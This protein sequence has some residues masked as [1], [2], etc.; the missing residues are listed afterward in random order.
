[1]IEE[2]LRKRLRPIVNRR[3]RLHL[4]YLLSACWII[5]ALV[6]IG[7]I[8]VN[9]YLGLKSPIA[10]WALCISAVLATLYALYR[11]RRIRPDYQA[12][13]RHIERQNPDMQALLLAAIEQEPEQPDDQFGYLQDR[14]IGEAVRHATKH[15]WL[16]S[17]SKRRLLSAELGGAIALALIITTLLQ[18]L[19]P[20]PFLRLTGR[21]AQQSRGYD[22]TVTPGDTSVE[23]G[24]PVVI[25]ARFGRRVPPKATLLFGESG[26]QMKQISLT[27]NLDDPVFGGIIQEVN[28]NL[29]YYIEYADKRSRDYKISIYERPVLTRADAKIIFPSYTKLPEKVIKDTRQ[30]SVAEGSQ[31]ILTFVLNKAVAK[32]QLVPK[33]G[34]GPELTVDGEHPNVYT[35]SITAAQN[36]RYE[37]HLADAQGLTNEVPERFVIDVHKNLP[38]ELKVVFPNR[39]VLASPLEELSLEAKVSDDYGVTG[40]GVSYTLAG[41]LSRDVTLGPSPVPSDKQQIQHLLALEELSAEP[42]QLLTYYFWADDVGPDGGIR[43]TSGDMYFA[44]IRPFEE[45]FRESQS[46]QNQQNQ[47]QQGQQQ[48][49]QQGE[50]LAQLQKQIISATWNIKRQADQAGSIDDGKEDLGVVHESQADVLEQARSASAQAED[51]A[52]DQNASGGSTAYGNIAG[53]SGRGG[54][55]RIGDGTDAGTRCRAIGLPGAAQIKTARASGWAKP[56]FQPKQQRT[57]GSLAAAIAAD[58]AYAK[59]ESIRD[60]APGPVSGADGPARGPSG[61]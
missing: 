57:F 48:G 5:A 2:A 32:A 51:P 20:V 58:G 7:L 14:V 8:I 21:N 45:I 9:R 49:R 44:E 24:S 19:P 34:T 38:P 17:I 22:I 37:L 54:R 39:D 52:A 25:L 18:L 50:Q 35:T 23:A 43:R 1:M 13:A 10:N 16:R 41:D 31:V 56:G 12:V 55:I 3:R 46:S 42:D 26:E 47:N 30:V 4:A 33:E 29:L 15:D 40:Y 36:Q 27:R 28:R 6:G 61:S 60:A 11:S 59:G 53:A